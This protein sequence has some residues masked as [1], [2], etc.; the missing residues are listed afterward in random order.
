MTIG[1]VDAAVRAV[2]DFVDAVGVDAKERV[3]QPAVA[4]GSG[5]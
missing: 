5:E 1:I 3:R 4:E 2:L